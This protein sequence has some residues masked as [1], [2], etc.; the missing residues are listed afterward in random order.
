MPLL[1]DGFGGT[2][3]DFY[4]DKDYSHACS[5]LMQCILLYG[6]LPRIGI[7]SPIN[8]LSMTS[9]P[10]L[11]RR[12]DRVHL[13]SVGWFLHEQW[14]ASQADSIN[15]LVRIIRNNEFNRKLISWFDNN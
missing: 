6:V 5:M 13:H 9:L 1:Q 2:V 4:H 7:E 8:A 10:V 15:K 11:K 14:P 3:V 12:F